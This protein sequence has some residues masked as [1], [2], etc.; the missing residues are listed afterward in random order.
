MLYCIWTGYE[1]YYFPPKNLKKE[2]G[3]FRISIQMLRTAVFTIIV[4][5]MVGNSRGEEII[6]MT[7]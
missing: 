6:A 7:V 4:Q 3:Y 2:L 1:I 5:C